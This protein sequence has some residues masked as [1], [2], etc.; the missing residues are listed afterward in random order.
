MLK[1]AGL[2]A[3]S[4]SLALGSAGAASA[5][6]SQRDHASSMKSRQHHVVKHHHARSI[7]HNGRHYVTDASGIGRYV[8]GPGDSPALIARSYPNIEPNP[9]SLRQIY[10]LRGRTM[11]EF[12]K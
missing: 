8:V 7:M 9:P 3:L 11:N 2:L 1:F 5:A 6:Q 10:S 12:H 4:A